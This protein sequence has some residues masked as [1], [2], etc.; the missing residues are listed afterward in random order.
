M[1]Q[2]IELGGQFGLRRRAF[3]A[4]I[5][6]TESEARGIELAAR[7]CTTSVCHP[8]RSGSTGQEKEITQMKE[9]RQQ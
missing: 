8:G 4:A 9:W 3:G 7:R 6:Q 1:T 2:E 5:A